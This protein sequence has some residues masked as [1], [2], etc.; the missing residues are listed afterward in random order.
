MAT[1]CTTT[2][3]T[4]DGVETVSHKE[5]E[6][7]IQGDVVNPAEYESVFMSKDTVEKSA[8]YIT[9]V[10]TDEVPEEILAQFEKMKS[11]D[12]TVQIDKTTVFTVAEKQPE[13]PGG[14]KAMES[15]IKENL[16]YPDTESCAQGRVVLSFIVEIDGT[17]SNIEVMRSPW[18]EFTKEAIRVVKMMPKWKPGTIKDT[19]VRVLYVL[20]VS[21]VFD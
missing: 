8:S 11:G 13:F 19:P 1:G 7:E 4:D 2:T 12:S 16:R 18:E 5:D 21:F 3:K 14:V 15:F 20:P 6:Y 10:V 17:I 9:D